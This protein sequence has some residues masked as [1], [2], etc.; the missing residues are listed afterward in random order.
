M[1]RLKLLKKTINEMSDTELVDFHERL[2]AERATRKPSEVTKRKERKAAGSKLTKLFES[3]PAE[4]RDKMLKE[5][6]K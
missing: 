6:T 5:L 1:D 2:R 4:L 3:L